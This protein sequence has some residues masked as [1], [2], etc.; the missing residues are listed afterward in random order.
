MR[1]DL[2]LQKDGQIGDVSF[3]GR[4][5]QI[6]GQATKEER[7]TEHF[8]F[9]F[10]PCIHCK[11]QIRYVRFI[12]NSQILSVNVLIGHFALNS[13]QCLAKIA[14]LSTQFQELFIYLIGLC[15]LADFYSNVTC[16][17]RKFRIS[18]KSWNQLNWNLLIVTIL[19]RWD[20]LSQRK[21][22][23]QIVCN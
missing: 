5:Q 15:R 19:T 8:G 21:N 6:E 12:D 13:F 4:Q 14:E 10:D 3:E 7:F 17:W 9:W 22:D 20:R 11:K 2:G 23:D 18:R 16:C 1:G